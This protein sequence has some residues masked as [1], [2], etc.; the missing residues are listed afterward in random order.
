MYINVEIKC[1]FYFS[2]I[3]K[4]RKIVGSSREVH[5]MDVIDES[6]TYVR[7]KKSVPRALP[8]GMGV[9]IL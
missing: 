9:Y 2:N 4:G 1:E 6:I 3:E 5:T 7:R 8:S